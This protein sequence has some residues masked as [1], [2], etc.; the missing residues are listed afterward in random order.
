MIT[1]V[2]ATA[3]MSN[4]AF[5][6]TTSQLLADIKILLGGITWFYKYF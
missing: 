4:A 6:V 5:I 1:F 3:I 2:M